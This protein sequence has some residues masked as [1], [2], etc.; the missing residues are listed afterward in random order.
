M[1]RPFHGNAPLTFLEFVAIASENAIMD[2]QDKRPFHGGPRTPKWHKYVSV[3]DFHGASSPN[4]EATYQTVF[5][6]HVF[7]QSTYQRQPWAGSRKPPNFLLPKPIVGPQNPYANPKF[8]G[9][10]WFSPKNRPNRV[11]QR[12]SF[13]SHRQL[14]QTFR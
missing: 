4:K 6:P 13:Y 12:K 14:P 11:Q 9:P 10:A 7:S 5:L 1:Y 2:D 8:G 3:K